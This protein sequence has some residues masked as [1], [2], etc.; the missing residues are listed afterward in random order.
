M[1]TGGFD[2]I[3]LEPRRPQPGA[4]RL[5]ASGIL[6]ALS[7]ITLAVLGYILTPS[8]EGFGRLEGLIWGVVAAG[9]AGVIAIICGIAAVRRKSAFGYLSILAGCPCLAILVPYA[10]QATA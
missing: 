7:P 9:P 5:A 1:D 3:T 8:S 4:H 6:I 2:R 10:L